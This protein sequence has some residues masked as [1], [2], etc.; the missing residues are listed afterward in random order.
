MFLVSLGYRDRLPRDDVC[1]LCP[2]G[3]ETDYPEMMSAPCVVSL[4]YRDGLPRDDVCSLCPW[5]IETDY[6]EMMRVPFCV[7][8]VYIVD[9]PFSGTRRHS[10]PPWLE[11]KLD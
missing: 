6:P 3:I 9:L 2:W 5:G 11:N 8:G 10:L 7:L 4:G 1:S